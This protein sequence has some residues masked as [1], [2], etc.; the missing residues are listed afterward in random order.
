MWSIVTNPANIFAKFICKVKQSPF[1]GICCC[2]LLASEAVVTA[3]GRL[4]KSATISFVCLWLLQVHCGE[5]AHST[6]PATAGKY[7]RM[8]QMAQGG[9][10]KCYCA[11]C[12]VAH[13]YWVGSPGSPTVFKERGYFIV[14]K[15]VIKSGHRKSSKD[16]IMDSQ[17]VQQ[18]TSCFS[19]LFPTTAKIY[20]RLPNMSL[21]NNALVATCIRGFTDSFQKKLYLGQRYRLYPESELH[22]KRCLQNQLQEVLNHLTITWK[23]LY[24][25]PT[26]DRTSLI[27]VHFVLTQVLAAINK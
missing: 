23:C 9:C 20:V 19:I 12:V 25:V 27:F 10:A 17:L 21:H 26:F 14:I 5:P 18:F 11:G 7:C 22:V 16:P 8:V 6:S 15:L 2:A 4:L 13:L 3:Q 24:S 1:G